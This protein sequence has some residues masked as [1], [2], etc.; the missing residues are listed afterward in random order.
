MYLYL[1]IY[2]YVSISIYN[3]YVLNLQQFTDLW[4]WALSVG[5]KGRR[6]GAPTAVAMASAALHLSKY[7]RVD[8][9]PKR[10]GD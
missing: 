9:G 5:P 7:G 6:K 4:P 1:Y 10:H 3:I 2:I 8:V